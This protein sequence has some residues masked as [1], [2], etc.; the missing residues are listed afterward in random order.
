MFWFYI[1]NSC[2][3]LDSFKA[4]S[5]VLTNDAGQY[6][7]LIESIT[8]SIEAYEPEITDFVSSGPLS[9]LS[10]FGTLRVQLTSCCIRVLYFVENF[11]QPI[12]VF[13]ALLCTVTRIDWRSLPR[14]SQTSHRAASP[15]SV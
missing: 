5:F 8:G 9:D 2:V 1:D 13:A 15:A 14:S 10:H 4:L 7:L 11:Y 12:L 6:G 3:S